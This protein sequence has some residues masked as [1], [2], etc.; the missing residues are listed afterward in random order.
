VAPLAITGAIYAPVYLASTRKARR[1]RP[2]R[3]F[4]FAP[5]WFIAAESAA[6]ASSPHTALPAG[7][8]PALPAGDA[9]A[10]S[11][12]GAPS[13]EYESQTGGASDSW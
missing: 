8:R 3:P 10:V 1:Y 5:V 12:F 4:E 9:P 7:S 6:E 2:G 11:A 13:A